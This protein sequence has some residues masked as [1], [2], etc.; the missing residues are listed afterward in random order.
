MTLW[1]DFVAAVAVNKTIPNAM[2]PA[3][4]AQA[5]A[6]QGR[7]EREL[8]V[9]ANNYWSLHWRIDIP[10][11]MDKFGKYYFVYL[12]D[13]PWYFKFY[14][15][16]DAI[17][18][19]WAFLHRYPYPH[20]DDCK[21]G[22]DLLTYIGPRF[23]PY[24]YTADYMR[25]H[26]GYNYAQFIL[27][28]L[29]PEATKALK[30]A[31]WEAIVEPTVIEPTKHVIKCGSLQG[32]EFIQASTKYSRYRINPTAVVLHY[33]ATMGGALDVAKFF[34]HSDGQDA[35][36]I[37][38]RD[39]KVIQCVN[40]DLSAWHSGLWEWNRKSIGIEIENYG[41]MDHCWGGKCWRGVN[42][43]KTVPQSECVQAV[44][45]ASSRLYWWPKYTDIQYDTVREI[46]KALR[47]AYPAIN[48]YVG[49]DMLGVAKMDPG[50]TWQWERVL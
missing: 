21:T 20:I 49:H 34:Q 3:V 27:E 10:F 40:F 14:N 32:V 31:G 28:M 43:L 30:E 41:W 8:S 5:I 39:G 35:H 47:V 45:K 15:L 19:Y 12:E 29:L 2:K 4:V 18:G 16:Q 37:V 13:N 44:G 24:G 25:L 23:C 17:D 9:K 36:L 1:T 7:A 42:V 11:P 22:V 26:Y 33:T 50:P 48:C 46:I 38:G 6:E